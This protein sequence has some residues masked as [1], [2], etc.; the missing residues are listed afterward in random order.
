[1]VVTAAAVAGQGAGA[2]EGG[3]GDPGDAEVAAGF[4]VEGCIRGDAGD[5]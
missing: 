5:E 3:K 4:I 1:M 2:L